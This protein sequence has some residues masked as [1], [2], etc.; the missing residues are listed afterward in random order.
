[1][2]G[3]DRILSRIAADSDESVR[4]IAANARKEADAIIAEAQQKAEA[5]AAEIALRAEK[6]QAQLKAGAQSRARLETGNALLKRRRAEI[7]KTIEE[8]ESTLLNLDTNEYFEAVYRLAARLKGKS[9][10]LCFN[11]KDLARLPDNFDKRINAAGLDATVS[12][13]P[14]SISG[15]FILK[16]GDIEENMDFAAL[17]SAKRDELEDLINRELFAQ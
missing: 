11:E 10:V 3:S 2:N 9:G 5:G 16:N 7:D 8:L 17:I 12:D 1:M 15:G 4:A 13:K 6:K 14:V